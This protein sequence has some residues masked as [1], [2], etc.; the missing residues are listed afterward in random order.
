MTHINKLRRSRGYDWE[1]NIVKYINSKEGYKA[2]RLGG[3]STGLPDVVITHNESSTIYA[4]EAKSV[5]LPNAYIP[6]DQIERCQYV[7]DMFGVYEYRFIWF[8]FKFATNRSLSQKKTDK[9]GN[10]IKTNQKKKI[11]LFKVI[12]IKNLKSIQS[13]NCNYNGMLSIIPDPNAKNLPLM[14]VESFYD[15]SALLVGESKQQVLV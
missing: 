13:I 3:S 9:K 15:E 4:I 14:N 10:I 1:Y 2:R 12:K 6:L 7:L 11:Y 8:A 5:T